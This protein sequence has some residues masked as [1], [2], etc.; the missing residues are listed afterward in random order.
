MECDKAS[1][2]GEC[3]NAVHGIMKKH[4]YTDIKESTEGAAGRRCGLHGEALKLVCL[5]EGRHYMSLM[6]AD[7]LTSG[8]Q[9]DAFGTGLRHRGLE[10]VMGEKRT[11]IGQ[12]MQAL[13]GWIAQAQEAAGQVTATIEAIGCDA[14]RLEN[15]LEDGAWYT[16]ESCYGSK[17]CALPPTEDAINYVVTEVWEPP[18]VAPQEV[19][20][21]P[22][23][24]S[25]LVPKPQPQPR[26]GARDATY[27]HF[28]VKHIDG[29]NVV[30]LH[31]VH[32]KVCYAAE[33]DSQLS[34]D[35]ELGQWPDRME[36][37]QLHVVYGAMDTLQFCSAHLGMLSVPSPEAPCCTNG[38]IG[39][40]DEHN[41]DRIF[42]F[43]KVDQ[44]VKLEDGSWC[45]LSRQRHPNLRYVSELLCDSG[46]YTFETHH[47]TVLHAPLGGGPGAKVMCDGGP[48]PWSDDHDMR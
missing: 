44:P 23:S 29:P 3:H 11:L 12:R 22:A 36:S 21:Q 46:R 20:V 28:L 35:G 8:P 42:V 10:Q 14:P 30:E 31:T 39:L 15:E 4:L 1:L 16:F 26:G 47:G 24:Q 7:C 45:P 19:P 27:S 25:P 38:S 9:V 5:E 6:C 48:L 34:C 33:A 37:R 41:D 32:G 43:R 2:C 18:A 40:L 13:Q 17:L